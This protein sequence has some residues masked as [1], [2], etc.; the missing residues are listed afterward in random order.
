MAKRTWTDWLTSPVQSA[1]AWASE[2]AD[3]VMGWV[4]KKIEGQMGQ[5]LGLG[6][7]PVPETSGTSAP[8]TPQART[9]TPAPATGSPSPAAGSA[10]TGTPAPAASGEKSIWQRITGLFSKEVDTSSGESEGEKKGFNWMGAIKTLGTVGIAAAGAY[11][12]WHAGGL[13][14]ALIGYAIAMFIAPV[15]DK[16]IDATGNMFSSKSPSGGRSP[17]VGGSSPEV[18]GPSQQVVANRA[19]TA[20]A[21]EE[22]FV[23]STVATVSS[24]M[25]NAKDSVIDKWEQATN[26]ARRKLGKPEQ[27]LTRV[28]A[29]TDKLDLPRLEREQGL[30][31]GLLSAVMHAE[32]RG[33]AGAVSPVGAAGLMQFMSATGKDYGMPNPQDRFDPQ[34]SVEGSAKYLGKL[35]K[36]FNGHVPSMLAAYNW[37]EGRVAKFN[38]DGTYV[39]Q[40]GKTRKY[41]PPA[42]TQ[43]Y[44][45][46][47]MAML[48]A[49]AQESTAIAAAKS[50]T[51]LADASATARG[52][53][54]GHTPTEEEK[55]K[56]AAKAQADAVLA[57]KAQAKP[58]ALAVNDRGT[59]GAFVDSPL[60]T[61][62]DTLAVARQSA[63]SMRTGG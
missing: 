17:E 48:P 37:G 22:G 29:Y 10:A 7:A 49:Y 61:P 14:G 1:K 34:K 12:G 42:E 43:H 36:Q 63:L 23:A 15:L 40:E 13:L 47:I 41:S 30:P 11:F 38:T 35:S 45:A 26:Y 19:A 18:S 25:G 53:S 46:K 9:A 58:S 39:D 57:A 2:T 55:A 5:V 52:G 6:A 60:Q 27:P 54:G 56:T 3:G 20:P 32:S 31:T 8:S 24:W 28:L 44:V 4:G 50:T 33:Q 59:R 51:L 16:V 62:S 21:K